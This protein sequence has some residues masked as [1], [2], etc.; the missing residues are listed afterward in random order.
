MMR[1]EA[2]LPPLNFQIHS[3]KKLYVRN[4]YMLLGVA[5]NNVTIRKKFEK[6]RTQNDIKKDHSKQ[7]RK[8]SKSK[9]SHY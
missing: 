2:I 9:W 7:I 5:I 6:L 3:C 1:A 8:N 4:C